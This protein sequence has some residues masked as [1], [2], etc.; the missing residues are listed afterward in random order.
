M[1]LK[2]IVAALGALTVSQSFAQ[3]VFEGPFVQG[4][5]GY[6]NVSPKFN[7]TLTVGQQTAS[8]Q[9]INADNLSVLTGNVGAG[10][11]FLIAPKFLLG[12]SVDF[13]PIASGSAKTT[14]SFPNSF[15]ILPSSIPGSYQMKNP[16]NISII[17]G[18]ELSKAQVIYGKVSYT[19]A[20]VIYSD[21]VTPAT[22]ANMTGYTLGVGYKQALENQLYVFAE[23]LYTK[24]QDQTVSM[25]GPAGITNFNLTAGA[26]GYTLLVGVGY[27]F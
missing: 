12:V 23:G 13:M 21:S 25:A 11:N 14:V 10:Y 24:F 6:T 19:G 4:A 26:S 18:Y 27:R 8:P 22:S 15:G 2:F 7:E 3:S 20:T 17:P 1:K 16:Y 9:N 5:L